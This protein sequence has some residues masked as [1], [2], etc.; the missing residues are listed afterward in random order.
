LP[1]VEYWRACAYDDL[2]DHQ[3][4]FVNQIIRQQ[5]VPEYMAAKDQDVF[6]ALAFEFGNLLVSGSAPDDAG[7]LP[8]F[9]LL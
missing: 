1:A 7:V 8:R 6:A 4:E 3:V 2:A 5:I 9:G